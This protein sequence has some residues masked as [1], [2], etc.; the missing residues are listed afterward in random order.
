M[1]GINHVR[2]RSFRLPERRRL[3]TSR[4][5]RRHRVAR[6]DPRTPVNSSTSSAAPE[7]SVQ[8]E[9][10]DEARRA[11]DGHD[12]KTRTTNWGPFAYVALGLLTSTL[13]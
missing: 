1:K 13:R 12:Q 2:D 9:A 10:E 8:G 4:P 6:H 11:D 7:A 3:G 5:S